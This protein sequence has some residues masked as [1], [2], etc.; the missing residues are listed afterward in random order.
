MSAVAV[1]A[2]VA[3]VGAKA[4]SEA[5]EARVV[6]VTVTRVAVRTTGPVGVQSDIRA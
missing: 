6:G 4:A 3:R 5:D 2:T 1:K